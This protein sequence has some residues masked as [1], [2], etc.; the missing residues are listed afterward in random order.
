MP[1]KRVFNK[2]KVIIVRDY[3]ELSQLA[4]KIVLKKIS[5]KKRFNL[6]VPTGTSPLGLYQLLSKKRDLKNCTFFNMDFYSTSVNGRSCVYWA[7][8]S[9]YIGYL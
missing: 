9:F 3:D 2:V 8:T 6:L 5:K 7:A 1:K 4:A